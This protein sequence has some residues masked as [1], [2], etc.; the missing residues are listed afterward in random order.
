MYHC[1]WN[2]S[3]C[4]IKCQQEHWHAEHKRTCRRKRWI[5]PLHRL[6]DIF[7][8]TLHFIISKTQY[9][10]TTCIPYPNQLLV[11]SVLDI[12]L[13]AQLQ[14]WS[15]E[16]LG[17]DTFCTFSLVLDLSFQPVCCQ[18]ILYCCADLCKELFWEHSWLG[19]FPSS[20]TKVTLI[21]ESVPCSFWNYCWDTQ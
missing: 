2:T 4:S 12:M 6:S 14:Y 15:A 11:C 18:M 3:Y 5:L 20:E 10:L 17:H 8:Q 16:I 13:T 1:C 7:P 21:W 9:L 19:L